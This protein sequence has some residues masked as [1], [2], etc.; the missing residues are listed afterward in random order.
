MFI[1]LSCK[2]PRPHGVCFPTCFPAPAVAVELRAKIA[3][4]KSSSSNRNRVEW[5]EKKPSAVDRQCVTEK[6]SNVIEASRSVADKEA[7]ATASSSSPSSRLC[8]HENEV[9]QW[10]DRHR[11]SFLLRSPLP[12]FSCVAFALHAR[13][14]PLSGPA[15]AFGL[16][17]LLLRQ[18][19]L[20]ILFLVDHHHRH[21][22]SYA[23]SPSLSLFLVLCFRRTA[24]LQR[25]SG[26]VH[27]QNEKSPFRQE[28]FEPFPML[29]CSVTFASGSCLCKTIDKS[30]FHACSVRQHRI[31]SPR[32]S[33]RVDDEKRKFSARSQDINP[34]LNHLWMLGEPSSLPMR[35]G[36]SNASQN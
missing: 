29:V 12:S 30:D 21:H 23:L 9:S 36:W 31:S 5:S 1:F 6:H 17:L 25:E 34:K 3:N 26:A 19:A 4:V 35:V 10:V 8:V 33:H 18:S 22:R 14:P 15:A 27:H 2:P 20:H 28:V 16:L 11:F 13:Q 32:V 24:S 7:I